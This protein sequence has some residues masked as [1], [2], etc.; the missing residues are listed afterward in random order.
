[1]TNLTEVALVNSE[2]L[3]RPEESVCMDKVAG[4]EN[5]IL[6]AFEGPDGSGKSTQLKL[7]KEWLIAQ[8]HDVLTTK[9]KSAPAIAPII[10]AR[11]QARTLG[12]EDYC[13]LHAA[14]FL[15]RME[16][17]IRPALKQCKIVLCD[18]YFFTALARDGARGLSKRWIQS[19]FEPILQPDLVF[20][21][22]VSPETCLRRIRATR[23]PKY[24]EAGQDVTHMADPSESFKGFIQCVIDEYERM[25]PKHDFVKVDAEETVPVQHRYLCARFKQRFGRA[26]ELHSQQWGQYPFSQLGIS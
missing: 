20:Y 3:P 21:F 8:G 22:S 10:K 12:P 24:Y 1:M 14:D 19:L 18:R 7:L 13:L 11:K 26:L 16:N 17:V 6:I 2:V 5:G 23:E 4:R 9:W 25:A 15:F